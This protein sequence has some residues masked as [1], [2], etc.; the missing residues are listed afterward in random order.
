MSDVPVCELCEK[1]PAA[2]Y[3]TE[4]ADNR[5]AKLFICR[6]CAES[7]GLLDE[8]PNV[9]ALLSSLV[10][11]AAAPAAGPAAPALR[12]S[13]CSLNF[14]RFQQRG[15]LGCPSC[16]AAFGE[17]LLRLLQ[18]IQPGT[19]HTGR[20]PGASGPGE[21]H[22]THLAHLRRELDLAVRT[23]AYERAAALRDALRAAESGVAAPAAAPIP[24]SA[25]S[26][27]GVADL[28]QRPSVWLRGEGPESDVVLSTR[29]RLARNLA[30]RVF[31]EDAGDTSR[32]ATLQEVLTRTATLPHASGMLQ[33][34]LAAL[35]ALERR[36]LAERQLL[37]Q[38]LVE[39]PLE[40]GVVFAGDES[41]AIMI[42][43]ED[44]LRL[45]SLLCGLDIRR[46]YAAVAALETGIGERLDLAFD[47]ALGYLTA[48]PSLTGTGMR[49]AVLLHLPGLVLE[50]R[51]DAE[52]STLH[53]RG[54][55]VRG[56]HGEGSAALGNLF[57]ISNSATLGLG[58][59]EILERLETV[60]HDLIVKEKQ[61]REA[62]LS[63]ARSLLEDRVWRSFGIL[64][65]ARRLSAQETLQHASMLRLGRATGILDVSLALVIDLLCLGQEAHTE[66][67]A[68][69][70]G[71]AL[72]GSLWRAATIR[73]KLEGSQN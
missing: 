32:K 53:R 31:P 10:T 2:L 45:Q 47:D 22:R 25:A 44:A 70:D 41:V 50:S 72:Q 7:R 35:T 37:S 4:I 54:V 38:D 13:R 36:I 56:S 39:A 16:Y 71:D 29:I 9:D 1:N 15:R 68:G 21:E 67:R 58:E 24:A 43:E 28:V 3:Y 51:M 69:S 66:Q 5:A 20:R 18:G 30:D 34:E 52:L 11:P 55:A 64:R 59:E 27:R 62:L 6:A 12:C 61:A 65:H 14:A 46:A 42:N 19:R 49:A 40:R 26:A 63:R 60:A 23:E 57:Q 33:F 73:G 48:S 8:T 17:A